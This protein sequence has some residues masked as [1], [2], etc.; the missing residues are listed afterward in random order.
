MKIDVQTPQAELEKLC[1]SVL[2]REL[3]RSTPLNLRQ[4]LR[5]T[6]LF[7]LFP[8]MVFGFKAGM[9]ITLLF[10][11][12]L[13]GVII[14]GSPAAATIGIYSWLALGIGVMLFVQVGVIRQAVV[15]NRRRRQYR[16]AVKGLK[17]AETL[18]TEHRLKWTASPRHKDFLVSSCVFR[19]PRKGIYAFL[20]T[21]DNYD[22]RR[23][24]TGGV[25]GTIIVHAQGKEG[26]ELRSL[27]LY[28]L[29]AGTHELT[30]AVPEATKGAPAAQLT[31][32]NRA[33]PTAAA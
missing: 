18:P 10:C 7:L 9:V 29:E 27:T 32:L 16:T 21:V 1:E 22:G 15:Q 20:L 24:I 31:L 25:T 19:A 4:F 28:R 6:L 17:H 23:I 26:Q 12:L 8:G 30:W 33:E 11:G 5:Y 2:R 3:L 13:G 14:C